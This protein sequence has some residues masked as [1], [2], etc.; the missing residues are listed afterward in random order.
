MMAGCLLLDELVPRQDLILE[1]LSSTTNENG[2]YASAI[3]EELAA[4]EVVLVSKEDHLAWAPELYVRYPKLA[5]ARLEGAVVD[6]NELMGQLRQHAD[7]GDEFA[8]TRLEYLEQGLTGL[9]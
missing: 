6:K 7:A 1:D 9:D 2:A 4:D 8:R 3:I 5:T